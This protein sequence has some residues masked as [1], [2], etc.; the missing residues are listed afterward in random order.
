MTAPDDAVARIVRVASRAPSA[1]NAQPWRI[2]RD[3][4][5][6]A[7]GLDGERLLTVGD[8]TGRDA[9]LGLG[10]W[11]EAAAVAASGEGFGFET[12]FDDAAL[13]AFS[14]DPTAAPAGALVRATLT[15]SSAGQPAGFTAD[16]VRA[17]AVH[18]GALAPITD[19][20]G[21]SAALGEDWLRIERVNPARSAAL[22]AL[23][24]AGSLGRRAVAREAVDWLRFT[25]RDPGFRRD[26]LTAPTLLIPS[27]AAA[28]AEA[29]KAMR[30]GRAVLEAGLAAA[31]RLAPLGARFARRGPGLFVLVA[32][33][34]A[35]AADGS[36]G[37]A[38]IAGS[39]GLPAGLPPREVIAAGRA[40][41]RAWLAA[42]RAAVSVAPASQVVDA[43]RA[44]A[45]LRRALGLRAPE[46]VLAVFAAGTP[47][48]PTP[49]APRLPV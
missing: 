48:G 44:H 42:H 41:L 38:G 23:G 37:A 17:R 49:R 13:A 12:A 34:R 40:L 43:P 27:A 11:L 24:D 25:P 2:A 45:E 30:A 22:V 9:L 19:D 15:E 14:A 10:C 28:L 6:L 8:P 35:L 16:D 18:R 36:S 32:D 39:P 4:A 3:G 47:T 33:G 1:H 21:M 26:G 31:S 46:T 5:A 7:V 20:G 29:L